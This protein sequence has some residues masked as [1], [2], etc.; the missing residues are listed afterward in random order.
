MYCIQWG[1]EYRTSLVFEWSKVVRLP[2]CP[3]FKCDLNIEL[4]LVWYSDHHLNNG[5][6]FECGLNTELPFDYQT[7]EYWTPKSFL[8]RCFRYS[9]VCYSDS[10]ST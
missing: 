1:S 3:L 2:N 9:D 4:N 5:P 8:F 6:L 7:S 10:H